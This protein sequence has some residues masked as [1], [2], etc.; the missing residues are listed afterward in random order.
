[1][2]PDRYQARCF[3]P[4]RVGCCRERYDDR[5]AFHVPLHGLP[6][7]DRLFLTGIAVLAAYRGRVDEFWALGCFHDLRI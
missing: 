2:S 1:M 4:E 3:G 6:R 7:H 5:R